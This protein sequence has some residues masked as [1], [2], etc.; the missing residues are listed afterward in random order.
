ME[1]K[2]YNKLIEEDYTMERVMW[3]LYDRLDEVEAEEK[4]VFEEI[5]QEMKERFAFRTIET[6]LLSETND[7]KRLF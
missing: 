4:M 6:E 3:D 1:K 5:G 7:Y 2:L